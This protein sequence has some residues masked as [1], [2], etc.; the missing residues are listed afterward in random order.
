MIPRKTFRIKRKNG[1]QRLKTA[2]TRK[3]TKSKLI[4]DADRLFSLKVRQYPFYR[5]FLLVHPEIMDGLNICY[6]CGRITEWKKLHCGHYLS[7]FYKSAR[8][9]FDNARPQCMMCNLWKKGDPIIFR[10]R[11]IKEIGIERVKAVEA[12]RHQSTKLTREY[13]ENKIKELS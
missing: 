13:L 9:D 2:R 11:L 3:K 12:K 1:L 6:T 8:W 4:K 5:S 7:R 10:Q